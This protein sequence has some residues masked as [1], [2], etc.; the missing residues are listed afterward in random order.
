M[1]FWDN[2]E[3]DGDRFSGGMNGGYNNRMGGGY[4]MNGGMN[5]G[6]GNQYNGS[7]GVGGGMNNGYSNQFGGMNSDGCGYKERFEQYSNKS[8][9]Q[10]MNEMFATVRRMKSEGSFDA[11]ALENLYNTAYPFLNEMQRQRMR[12]IIDMITK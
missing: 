2:K 10:L 11:A 5:S 4:G 1:N 7:N 9:E 12:S 8:E 3:G 6:C